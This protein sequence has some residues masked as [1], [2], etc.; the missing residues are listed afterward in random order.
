[1]KPWRGH[2]E[3]KSEV[4]SNNPP[5]PEN[6]SS[7]CMSQTGKQWVSEVKSLAKTQRPGVR[8]F[9][10]DSKTTFL[11]PQSLFLLLAHVS[12]EWQAEAGEGP[13]VKVCCGSIHELI[14][15]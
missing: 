5:Q 15:Y 6:S 4:F 7:I 11:P 10:W 9:S 12:T 14:L 2:S 3:R 8:D 13:G 1:M